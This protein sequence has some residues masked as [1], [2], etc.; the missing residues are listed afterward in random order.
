MT[1]SLFSFISILS[2]EANYPDFCTDQQGKFE[3]WNGKKR[4]CSWASGKNKSKRCK[5][6]RVKEACPKTCGVC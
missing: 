6:Q 2:C 1:Y 3:L 5:I 4:S